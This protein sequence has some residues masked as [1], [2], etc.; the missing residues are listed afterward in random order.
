[1]R[2]WV[3]DSHSRGLNDP[4]AEKAALRNRFPGLLT[5]HGAWNNLPVYPSASHVSSHIVF[6]QEWFYKDMQGRVQGPF[7]SSQMSRWWNDPNYRSHFSNLLCRRG[8]QGEPRG[9]VG[10]GGRMVRVGVGR[11]SSVLGDSEW[12]HVEEE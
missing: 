5:A 11:S 10:C 4:Q 2:D 9:G 3:T 12:G 6:P 8:K 1:M 7:R